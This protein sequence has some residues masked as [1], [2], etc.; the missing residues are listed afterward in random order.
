MVTK[1]YISKISYEEAL[2][3]YGEPSEAT[4]FENAKQNEI[5]PGIRAGIGKYYKG[6]VKISIKEA[7]WN[8]NDSI[9]IAVWYTKKQNQWMPFDS[10]E[11]NRHTDF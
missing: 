4:V 6:G 5:F 9:Q 10:F 11:Y 3:Y 2:S 7:I 1:E 8:K